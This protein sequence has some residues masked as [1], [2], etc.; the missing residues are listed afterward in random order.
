MPKPVCVAC[1]C[2]YRP[3]KNGFYFTEMMPN[4]THQGPA[5]ERRG[6]HMPEAWQPYKVWTSDMYECPECH[7]QILVGFGNQPSVEHY[8]DEFETLQM[9]LGATQ[10]L[11][12]DC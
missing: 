10:L 12:N 5:E 7:H 3:K 2:F 9:S 11:V 1:Q 4:G 6:K 8:Q